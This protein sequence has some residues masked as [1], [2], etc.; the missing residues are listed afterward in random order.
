M[1]GL[2]GQVLK[3]DAVTNAKRGGVYFIMSPEEVIIRKPGAVSDVWDH[4]PHA[5]RTDAGAEAASDAELGIHHVFETP[6]FSLLACDR[7]VITGGLA[8]VAV[9]A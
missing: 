9:P 7:T 2:S 1:P 4:L 8:H 6:L 5:A 3:R